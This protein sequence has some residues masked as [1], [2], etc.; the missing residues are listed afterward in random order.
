MEMSSSQIN[1]Y[2]KC[3]VIPRNASQISIVFVHG[4]QSFN[5]P[6]HCNTKG[7]ALKLNA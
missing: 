4:I 6:Y 7:L 1:F 5:W 3:T 2:K